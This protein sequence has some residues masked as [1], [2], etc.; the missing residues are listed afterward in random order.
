[1]RFAA[2]NMSLERV[3][4][5]LQRVDAAAWE[6][7]N[8]S[9]RANSRRL[10]RKIEIAFYVKI[11][12]PQ[13]E[14]TAPWGTVTTVQPQYKWEE[15]EDRIWQR[16]RQRWSEAVIAEVAQVQRRYP[17]LVADEQWQS[18][19]P[20]WWQE[21]SRYLAG[22]IDEATCQRGCALRDWQYAKKQRTWLKK[23]LSDET[24]LV[25]EGEVVAD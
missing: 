23:L 5:W 8:E 21:I 15:I 25:N 13:M 12:Q 11:Y 3:Q 10:V 20:L 1:V 9:D 16:V 19:M 22:K 6:Q 7:L 2:E 18:R 14:K 24:N 17:Q 4:A